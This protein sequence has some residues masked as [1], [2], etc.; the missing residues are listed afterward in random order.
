MNLEEKVK[1]VKV[2]IMG[3]MQVGKTCIIKSYMENQS[4]RGKHISNTAN[5]VQDFVKTVNVELDSGL[6]QRL[7]LNIWDA[8]GDQNVHNLAHLFVKD[9]QC[10]ILV[11]SVDSKISFD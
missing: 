9:V 10:G 8:A 11:Y 1:S 6:N 7:K 4:M 5:I 2:I 3:N